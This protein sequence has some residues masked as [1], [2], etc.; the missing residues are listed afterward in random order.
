M[1]SALIVAALTVLIGLA[2]T[3]RSS[4]A[5]EA[6]AA[7]TSGEAQMAALYEEDPSNDLGKRFAGSVT[8]RTEMVSPGPGE[9]PELVVRAD[10]EVPERKLA[11]TWSLRRNTDKSLPAS[12]IVE[13]TF[14]PSPDLSPGSI[15]NVPGML[16][17]RTE[18]TRGVPLVGQAVKVVDGSFLIR[19]STLEADKQRNLQMLKER[20]WLDIPVVYPND[21]RAVLAIEK[22]TSGE[23]AFAEAFKA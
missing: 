9:P 22:G 1:R 3:L 10:V 17:K 2:P 6:P 20:G 19:L 11:I 14:K 16:M 7:L 5:L 13:I 18:I 21:R 4:V 12:H 23:R 15:S 8:W